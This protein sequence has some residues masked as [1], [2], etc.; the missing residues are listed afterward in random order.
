MAMGTKFAALVAGV[1]QCD[2]LPPEP[3]ELGGGFAVSGAPRGADVSVWRELDGTYRTDQ[4]MR[5]NLWVWTEQ[6]SER[7]GVND[8]ENEQLSDRAMA[9]LW[10]MQLHEPPIIRHS[11]TITGEVVD[12]RPRVNATTGREPV[13]QHHRRDVQ[14][15]VPWLRA[16]ATT[17]AAFYERVHVE[18]LQGV[19]A[20]GIIALKKGF[21]EEHIDGAHLEFERALEGLMFPRRRDDFVASGSR[22]LRDLRRPDGDASGLLQQ[23]YQARN[24]YGHCWPIRLARAFEDLPE[25]VEDRL[26]AGKALRDATYLFA[27]RAYRQVLRDRDLT[28][29]FRADGSRTEIDALQR[30]WRAVERG[31]E[32]PPFCVE[33]AEEDWSPVLGQ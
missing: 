25:S 31:D 6:P 29:R 1:P 2:L 9:F 12:G 27:V 18:N 19:V 4:I 16:V 5:S 23:I 11:W 24:D 14:A 28:N 33:L 20:R 30:Y 26:D 32:T 7:A 3:I 8:R 17:A 10:A 22:V 13:W 21:T 15:T